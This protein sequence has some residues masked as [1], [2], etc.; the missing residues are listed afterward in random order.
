[1]STL[2]NDRALKLLDRF[3]DTS[4]SHEETAD[5]I[6]E[7]VTQCHR[8]GFQTVMIV[9]EENRGVLVRVTRDGSGWEFSHMTGTNA[10][11]QYL[12]G[13]AALAENVVEKLAESYHEFIMGRD[14]AG[15]E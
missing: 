14:L 1:M 4:L 12:G 6:A 10:I 8:R 3:S 11:R 13:P 7:V 9:S 2:D 15:A 5:F